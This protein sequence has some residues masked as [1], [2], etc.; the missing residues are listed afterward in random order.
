MTTRPVL[1]LAAVLLALG[2]ACRPERSGSEPRE[3]APPTPV[4]VRG[5]LG[6]RLDDYLRRFARFGFS[7]AVL[8]AKRDTVVLQNGYGL[9]DREAGLAVQPGTV[10]DL[11]SLT[12]QFTATAILA[13][14][15]RRKLKTGDPIG[16]FFAN[17]PADKA[18]IT[19]HHLLT[20]TAGLP[21]ALGGDF[22]AVSRDS[23]VRLALSTPLRR[24]PG[25]EYEY[26]NVGYSLLGAIIEIVTREPYERFLQQA[27]FEPAGLRE[28]GYG[29]D[30]WDASRLAQGYDGVERWGTTPGR[31][32][33]AGPGWHLQANGGIHSTVADV[34]RWL[35]ALDSGA[36]LQDASRK[37]QLTPWVPE[38]PSGETRYGYGWV[39]SSTVGGGRLIEHNGGNGVFFADVRRYV[40]DSLDL[41][42]LTN[43]AENETVERHLARLALGESPPEVPAPSDAVD[44]GDLSRYAG[45]YR[46]PSG[47][48]LE[49]RLEQSQ[50]MI[51]AT[52]PEI[53]M[54]FAGLTP[55]GG[56]PSLRPV[57]TE[58]VASRLLGAAARG[59]LGPL[60]KLLSSA[61]ETSVAPD[62]AF[63]SDTFEQWASRLG[64]FEGARLIGTRFLSMRPGA[65]LET[66]VVVRYQRGVRLAKFLEFDA[67]GKPGITLAT[68]PPGPLPPSRLLLVPVGPGRF[69]TFSASFGAEQRVRFVDRGGKVAE[70]IIE[71]PGKAARATRVAPAG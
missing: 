1:A 37:K 63:W 28:T 56:D 8:V 70:L 14:E 21:E 7:G 64:D 58:P 31:F 38:D 52:D 35:R 36:I 54:L 67:G 57:V 40:D 11:G 32:G 61:E 62:A 19:V 68:V 53:G 22:E 48:T 26:S 46:L 10:F 30:R 2:P 43:A 3:P 6:E 9:A 13:L 20:H 69:A 50:L 16:R 65:P 24:L 5:P 18:G 47:L 59:D 55:P 39:L 66:W 42:F 29:P 60:M 27:L 15:E 45:A 17:V 51:P 23:L 44:P 12:K 25:T 4:I 41:V 33:S 49:V 71:R 34:Y